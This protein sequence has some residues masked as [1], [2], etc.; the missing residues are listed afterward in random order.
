MLCM[1]SRLRWSSTLAG[2]EY[3]VS[4]H[5]NP[6]HVCRLH[7]ECSRLS[8]ALSKYRHHTERSLPHKRLMDRCRDQCSLLRTRS[9][10][11]AQTN[12]VVHI[13]HY[14]KLYTGW[15]DHHHR[16]C[17]LQRMAYMM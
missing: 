5:R 1:L 4:R 17:G 14:H 13:V 8:R 9:I 12:L 15:T 11:W 6:D 3:M 7:M 10:R 2:T 16:H